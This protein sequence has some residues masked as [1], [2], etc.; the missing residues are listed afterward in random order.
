GAVPLAGRFRGYEVCTPP[1]AF[2]IV[3]TLHLLEGFDLRGF[4]HNSAD[5]LH[6]LIEAIKVAS[7]DRVAHGTGR[8]S[9]PIAGLLSP[10]YA[11]ERRRL[12]DPARAGVSGGERF[13]RARLPGE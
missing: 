2:Q 3:Q 1:Y 9:V 10:A 7:A 6:H 12:I 11:A 4:G 13:E 5:Y 8:G